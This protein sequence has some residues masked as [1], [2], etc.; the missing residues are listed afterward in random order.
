[1]VYDNLLGMNFKD[2]KTAPY[3]GY[4]HHNLSVEPTRPQQG[5]I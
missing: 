2:S 5:M 4:I 3:V 1:M